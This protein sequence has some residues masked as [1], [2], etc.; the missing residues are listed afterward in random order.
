MGIKDF[1]AFEYLALAYASI[2]AVSKHRTGHLSSE[3]EKAIITNCLSFYRAGAFGPQTTNLK[4]MS[5]LYN[6]HSNLYLT[7][8]E[9]KSS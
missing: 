5:F 3:V 1:L 9:S 2:I 7:Q 6:S 4:E 8:I